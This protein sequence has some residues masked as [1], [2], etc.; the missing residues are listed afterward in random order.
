V[1][2]AKGLVEALVYAG[3]RGSPLFF[4]AAFSLLIWVFGF[5]VPNT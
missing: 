3:A 5:M 4:F 1:P 2:E